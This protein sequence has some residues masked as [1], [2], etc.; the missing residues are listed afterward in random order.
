MIS[1]KTMLKR[2]IISKRTIILKRI[3]S[4]IMIDKKDNIKKN[5]R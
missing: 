4:R 1:R 2:T 3:I 5:N